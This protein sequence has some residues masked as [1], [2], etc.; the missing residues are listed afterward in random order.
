MTEAMKE[1]T[2]GALFCRA[3]GNLSRGGGAYDDFEHR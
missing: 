1:F 2:K 3:T